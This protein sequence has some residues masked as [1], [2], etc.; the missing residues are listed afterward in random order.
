[1]QQPKII[2]SAFLIGA[3]TSLSRVLGLV[4]DFLTAGLFGTSLA[5]SSFVVAFRIPNLFRALFGEGALASAFVPIFIE[6]RQKA[7]DNRAWVFVRNVISLIGL[8]LLTVVGVGLLGLT[9]AVYSGRFDARM[10][11]IL[12]LLRIML[13]YMMFICLAALAQAILNS[14]RRFALPAFTPALL[15]L[16]WIVFIAFVCPQ[17]P[18]PLERRIF[19]LAW[20]VLLAGLIQLGV[21]LP[22]L[23]RLGYRPGFALNLADPRVRRVFILMGP[24]ALGL[25]VYQINA[26]IDSF[27]AA[28]VGP[29]APAALFFSERL[30]YFPQ[31]ILAAALSTV[32]L[33]VLS[34][35]AANQDYPRIRETLNQSLRSLLF[36]MIPAAVGLLVLARPIIEMIYQW[37]RFDNW[38][39]VLTSRA[40][41]FY[42]PGLVVFCLAKVFVP[43]FYATKDTKTPVRIGLACVALNFALNITFILTFP[44]YWKH[45]GLALATVISEGVNGLTLAWFVHRKIGPLGWRQIVM[46][47]GRIFVAAGIMGPL[48]WS[49][50]RTLYA[51]LAPSLPAKLAQITAVMGGIA[52][53]VVFYGIITRLLQCPE[54]Q[55]VRQALTRRQPG[56]MARSASVSD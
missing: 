34:D 8:V 45:A 11:L 54:W 41:W 9:L 36:V 12:S 6:E 35:H 23:I 56:S 48:A 25:A 19:G 55:T 32:L 38:S 22:A 4:R 13:P 7:G 40:L 51:A 10:V 26:A 15:N 46:S 52:V 37:R 49:A 47:V 21:Q 29:W 24:A 3:F 27:L 17:I 2:R 1:M 43:A 14:Y 53:A 44:E 33:P 31:G 28:W 42:S 30:L 5:M 18:G 50:R 20:G 39:T 16:T